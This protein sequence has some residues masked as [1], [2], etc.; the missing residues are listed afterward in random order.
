M[1]AALLV[2]GRV[3]VVAEDQLGP[4]ARDLARR[5]R[6]LHMSEVAEELH[7]PGQPLGGNGI[8][9]AARLQLQHVQNLAARSDQ[10]AQRVGQG[11]GH[12]LPLPVVQLVARGIGGVL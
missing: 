9:R 11:K 5:A 6:R 12:A 2:P 4:D 3:Q 7:G 1:L 10:P 8:L